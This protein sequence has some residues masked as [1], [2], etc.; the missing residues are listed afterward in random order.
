[1]FPP[2]RQQ[3]VKNTQT[4]EIKEDTSILPA[5]K[6]SSPLIGDNEKPAAMIKEEIAVLE[7]DKLRVELSNVGG[8]IK[9]IYLKEYGT[10]LP[11]RDIFDIRSQKRE[12]YAIV[13]A[14]PDRVIYQASL[15]GA[16]VRKEFR[17]D[18][19]EYTISINVQSDKMSNLIISGYTL[20]TSA[21]DPKIINSPEKSLYEYSVSLINEIIRKTDAIE[22]HVKENK[23]QAGEVSWI[24]FRDRYFCFVLKPEFKTSQYSIDVEEKRRL[25]I[26]M[27]PAADIQELSADIY[28]G[29]QILNKLASYNKG[30]EQIMVFSRYGVLDICAKFIYFF[31]HFLQGVLKNWGVAIILL[32]I[33]IFFATYP[34][35]AKSMASMKKMQEIQPKMKALQEKYKNDPQKMNKEMMELYKENNVN[36]FGGCLPMLLQ[37]PIFIGLYQVLWRSVDFKGA[38]FLWIKDLSQPDRLFM[39][40]INIPFIGNEFNILPLLMAIIMYFQ[41]KFSSMSMTITDPAQLMQQK[42]M[43]VVM[44]VMMGFIF[45]HFAS[46]LTLYF[47]IFYLMSTLAQLRMSKLSKVAV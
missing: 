31:I 12:K 37:M 43:L 22:F 20:D 32:G 9:T 35:T 23:V 13:P 11:V 18:K 36:P 24:G 29:P 16:K 30:F 40:P 38:G 10:T 25:S 26:N 8:V 21:V 6:A 41:Q 33:S 27:K 17:L 2:P 39:L 15:N 44:P 5:Q 46:G 14:S 42:M 34:L 47:S 7:N 45:Y 28:A 4:S 1:M 19:N 3:I